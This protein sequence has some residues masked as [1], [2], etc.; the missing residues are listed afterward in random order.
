M[1]N[2]ITYAIEGAAVVMAGAA[3]AA[4]ITDQEEPET[5]SQPSSSERAASSPSAATPRTILKHSE[6]ALLLRF[7]R[8]PN[9]APSHPAS[10]EPL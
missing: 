7:T 4:V 9:C 3:G 10:W 5:G 2:P 6:V 8:R 1:G